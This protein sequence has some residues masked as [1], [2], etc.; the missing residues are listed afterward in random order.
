MSTMSVPRGR[1]RVGAVIAVAVAAGLVAWLLL[2]GNGSSSDAKTPSSGAEAVTAQQLSQLAVTL[3]HPI[4][5]LGPKHG[6]TYELTKLANGNIYVRYL[7]AG[8]QVGANKPYLTV[9][10]YP[11]PGAAAA[12]QKQASAT[13]AMTTRLAHHGLAVLDAQYPESTHAAYRNVNY[14]VEV[15][16][17]TPRAALQ[18]ASGLRYLGR[19]SWHPASIQAAMRPAEVSVAGLKTH[20]RALGH[21]IYWA[22]PKRGLTYELSAT[23][24]GSVFVRYLP[25]GVKPGS[26]TPYLSVATYPFPDAL[27][28]LQRTAKSGATIRLAHGG[29]AIV[30]SSYPKSIHIAFPGSNYEIEV[31][32]PS[33]RV[34]R[35]VAASGAIAPVP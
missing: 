20:A 6:F 9:A 3:H 10:T 14:E 31:F 17:P 34:A 24:N 26:T 15:Y 29:I 25:P 1:V 23:S 22:G 13:G 30:D 19:L 33:P 16:D 5:W 8:V 32:D 4:F 18:L 27:A 35:T 7:P 28:A 11:F 12:M 2:R 21:P